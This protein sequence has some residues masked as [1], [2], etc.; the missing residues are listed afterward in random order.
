MQAFISE[1]G[2]MGGGC[3]SKVILVI[4]EC[5]DGKST[6]VNALRDMDN[7]PGDGECA[8]D[9]DADGVTKEITRYPGK[10]INGQE[11]EIL[12][13]PGVGDGE[14]SAVALVG[15][16]QEEL[17]AQQ[18]DGVVVT[19]QIIAGRLRL[20]ARVVME[21]VKSDAFR[22][23]TPQAKWANVI[24]CG[25]MRDMAKYKPGCMETFMLDKNVI[26]EN[27][28]P[29][30]VVATFFQQAPDRWG[31][32]AL[33]DKDDYS[34]L[35]HAISQLP[36]IPIQYIKKSPLELATLLCNTI[37]V[38]QDK[39]KEEFEKALAEREAKFQQ[40]LVERDAKYAQELAV[41]DEEHKRKLE[42]I[43]KQR[44]DDME[45]TQKRIQEIQERQEKE[46]KAAE[47]EAQLRKAEF[48]KKM[49][50][51]E[52]EYDKERVNLKKELDQKREEME[53]ALNE[54]LAEQQKRRD[55]ST[56][57][58]QRLQNQYKTV[59]LGGGSYSDGY[60]GNRGSRSMGGYGGGRVIYT[61]PRGGRYYINANGNKTY[62]KR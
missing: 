33:V 59:A 38:S 36:N 47:A 45:A 35:Q 7:A 22:G 62:V 52:R 18:I 50:E 12:D 4:G 14:V 10:P 11:I 29:K 44:K 9:E 61:G 3:R 48:Q 39:F 23:D 34:E 19:T 51:L 53:R 2:Q 6:L 21:L 58:M 42:K 41:A 20:G 57:Q 60:G 37:G 16:I 24:L 43:E 32:C 1:H 54:K 55:D 40:L 56:L 8:V 5:G 30:G 31:R 26:K 46:R 13:T 15:M 27:G 25:T 17:G 28:N 49:S